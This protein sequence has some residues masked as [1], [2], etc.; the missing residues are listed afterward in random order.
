MAETALGV[1]KRASG[2]SIALGILM[3]V[4]GVLAI[5]DSLT[6][7]VVV[8]IFVAWMAIFNGVVQIV[9]GFR[10]ETGGRLV[11]EI[12]LGL[13]YIVAGGFI[14]MHPAGGLLAL[15]LIIASF[16]VVYGVFAIVLAFQ[17]RPHK[18]WGWVLFDALITLLLGC[19]IW[20]H[21]PLNSEWVVGTLLGI[22]FIVSGVSRLMISM[23]VRN[24]SSAAA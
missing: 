5:A 19:L 10:A 15:T 13:L 16:L 3:I 17:L 9:Y 23:A 11:L 20:A 18:G 14:L 4:A 1:V 8:V 12:L 6:A 2:W 24:V 21:W 22:S 7:G